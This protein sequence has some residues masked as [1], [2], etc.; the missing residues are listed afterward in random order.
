MLVL[1]ACA[2]VYDLTLVVAGEWILKHVV[3]APE[4]NMG[5]R[6]AGKAARDN[7]RLDNRSPYWLDIDEVQVSC[8]CLKVG[9]LAGT[10]TPFSSTTAAISLHPGQSQGPM[11]QFIAMSATLE[12]IFTRKTKTIKIRTL[13]TFFAHTDP[14]NPSLEFGEVPS[15]S[16]AG[17]SRSIVLRPSSGLKW[18]S[19]AVDSETSPFAKAT[20]D[21]AKLAE[22]AKVTVNLQRDK[23]VG[24]FLEQVPLRL[25]GEGAAEIINLP[26]SGYCAWE[27]RSSPGMLIFTGSNKALRLTFSPESS[28]GN[29][30]KLEDL[31]IAGTHEGGF[32]IAKPTVTSD[33]QIAYDVTWNGGGG[34]RSGIL[35]LNV[36]LD[37]KT[38]TLG[39][40][41]II[42]PR[43]RA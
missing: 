10:G 13:C 37:G 29:A 32:T 4:V 14:L 42:A 6:E 38:K 16:G 17:V 22:G 5:Q 36:K 24:A 40:P 27:W 2:S 25:Q 11:S 9:K 8:E 21:I 30:P 35:G 39:V 20:V 18:T 33:G 28:A 15:I 34:P 23:F 3:Q 31:E 43:T 7:L 26:V 41:F 19:I 1:A 12:G